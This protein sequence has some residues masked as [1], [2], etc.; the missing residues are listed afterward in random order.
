[1]HIKKALTVVL[2]VL[3]FLSLGAADPNASDQ[4][5]Y[6]LH[7]LKGLPQQSGGRVLSGQFI[8]WLSMEDPNLFLRIHDATTKYPAIMSGNYAD[9][10]KDIMEFG[11]TNTYLINQW[12]GG[13]LVEVGI[14]FNNPT[15]NLWDMSTSV[16]MVKLISPGEELNTKFN[17]QL[18]RIVQGLTALQRTGVVVLF[19]PFME[20]NG[21]WFWWGNK[22]QNEFINV[23]RY[24][25]NYLTKQNNLHNL[26]WIYS[27]SANYGKA[28]S[29]YPG[30]EY[31]DIVGLDYYSS[32]GYFEA[33]EEYHQLLKTG[34]P[35]ALSELGQC[36][37][38]GY[39]CYSKNAMESITSIR[40]E[41]PMIVY[42]SNWNEKWAM[43]RQYNLPKLM[44]DPWIINREDLKLR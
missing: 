38:S 39:N 3:S 27:V 10:G 34:K 43:D 4:T 33:T 12:E 18:D 1:M 35:I 5:E 24:T 37:S 8:G 11:T 13:G 6:V 16:D 17:K 2:C 25:F 31:V 23:W 28:L 41:M 40:D 9:F 20:V 22:D 19:R 32:S 15:N 21:Y 14:H 44:N 26:L 36:R 29:Y 30:D 42:W 7:Y